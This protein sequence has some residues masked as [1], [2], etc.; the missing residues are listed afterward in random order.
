M[1]LNP[2][3]R[4]FVPKAFQAEPKAKEGAPFFIPLA[5]PLPPTS[6]M[7][8][9]YD[10]LQKMYNESQREVAALKRT[11]QMLKSEYDKMYDE[12]EQ[13]KNNYYYLNTDYDELKAV[14][15]TLES[16]YSGLKEAHRAICEDE[17]SLRLEIELHQNKIMDLEKKNKTFFATIQ[18]SKNKQ[19]SMEESISNLEEENRALQKSATLQKDELDSKVADYEEKIADLQNRLSDA[20]LRFIEKFGETEKARSEAAYNAE[21]AIHQKNMKA[22]ELIE[23][24]AQWEQERSILQMTL[25]SLSANYE[26]KKGE[27]A[28]YKE[29]FQNYE[30]RIIELQ[31]YNGIIGHLYT[32]PSKPTRRIM[33]PETD[34]DSDLEEAA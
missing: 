24:R 23:A 17:D 21:L 9:R 22:K 18:Q 16:K 14:Y 6:M 34:Y 33:N 15:V 2:H 30:R 8:F 7:H 26:E 5:P 25:N 32:P 20:I 12:L 13:Q 19:F 29:I 3:A 11:N 4:E 27:V 1:S 10:E 31:A 28:Y